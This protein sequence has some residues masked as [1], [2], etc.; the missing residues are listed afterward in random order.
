M[1]PSKE[2][3]NIINSRLPGTKL[4]AQDVEILPFRVFDDAIT[5]RYTVMTDEMMQK[6]VRDLN[7]GRAAFNRLHRSS[8]T[9]PVG[10]S[11]NA[12]IVTSEK[13]ELH[14]NMYAVIRRPDGTEME[15]GKDLAD[16]YNTGAVYAC[17]AGVM[18]GFYRCGICGNDIRNWNDCEHIPGRTYMVNEKPE[19]CIAYMT[20]RNI[21]NGVAEDCGIYEVSAVTAG[22]SLRAGVLTETFGQ[23]SEGVD[24]SE[25]KKEHLTKDIGKETFISFQPHY[26]SATYEE[27]KPMSMSKEEIKALVEDTYGPVTQENARLKVEAEQFKQS[28]ADLTGKL[29]GVTAEFEALKTASA[30]ATAQFEALKGQLETLEAFKAVY[31]GLVE[32]AGVKVNESADYAAMTLDQLKETYAGYLDKLSALPHGQQTVE[33]EETGTRYA[34]LPDAAFKM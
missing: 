32:A 7:E 19:V 18:V 27:E 25:F 34:S 28:V 10:R 14:A 22:G 21:V 23:Y 20:G 16:R 24:A 11:V 17:S 4:S 15:D 3:L 26:E 12:R 5:D 30:E 8:T 31:V 33:G 6:L 2:Q 29:E 13:R 1:K 9:L